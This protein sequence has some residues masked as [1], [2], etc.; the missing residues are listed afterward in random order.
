[1]PKEESLSVPFEDLARDRFILGNAEECRS[2]IERHARTL[3]VNHFIFRL[4]W[5]GMPQADALGQIEQL[6]REVVHRISSAPS[7]V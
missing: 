2:D 3:G 5:P 6:G 1:M 7:G 4:Q